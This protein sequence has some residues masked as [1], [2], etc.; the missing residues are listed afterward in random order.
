MEENEKIEQ[1][2]MN[3][4]LRMLRDLSNLEAFQVWRDI[5]A[6]P[7]I[8]QLEMEL[9]SEKSDSISEAILRGKLKQ[10]NSLKHIFYQVFEIAK[11]NLKSNK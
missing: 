1:E 8:A 4:Q 11:Q 2:E 10:L 7:I 5:V 3:N 6:E 9:A